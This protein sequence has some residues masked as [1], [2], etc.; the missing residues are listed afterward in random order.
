LPNRHRPAASR[1]YFSIWNVMAALHPS[2]AMRQ[3]DGSVRSPSWRS[4]FTGDSRGHTSRV[5]VSWIRQAWSWLWRS[6]PFPPPVPNEQC[7][8]CHQPI[9]VA[10][11][12]HLGSVFSGPMLS[13]RTRPE[14]IAACP[15]HGRS[16]FNDASV[17]AALW[18]RLR[19]PRVTPDADHIDVRKC[20]RPRSRSRL[21]P[22]GISLRALTRGQARRSVAYV[23]H[24]RRR[25]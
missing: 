22:P 6:F 2:R 14:L 24:T 19:S 1:A 17:K 11:T 15:L 13:P 12:T 25:S 4:R 16:P 10:A 5:A 20:V 18:I 9:V 3:I 21:H 7:P 23:V 8:I